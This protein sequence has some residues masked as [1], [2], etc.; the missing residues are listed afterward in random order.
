ME[1]DSRRNAS[2]IYMLE[3]QCSQTQN[4]DATDPHRITQET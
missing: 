2:D 1:S 3:L 4:E